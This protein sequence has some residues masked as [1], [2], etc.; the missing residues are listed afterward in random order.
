MS[1][2]NQK[3]IITEEEVTEAAKTACESH[4]EILYSKFEDCFDADFPS[5]L[6]PLAYLMYC[7]GYA[8]AICDA[9]ITIEVTVKNEGENENEEVCRID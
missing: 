8:D 1:E 7:T 3:P 5:E 4:K 2:K 9:A 6:E